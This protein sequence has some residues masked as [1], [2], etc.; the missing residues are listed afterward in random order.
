[1]SSINPNHFARRCS[2]FS[3]INRKWST[4]L[5]SF[6]AD[7]NE[8]LACWNDHASGYIH[9]RHLSVLLKEDVEIRSCLQRMIGLGKTIESEFFKADRLLDEGE[10]E[11]DET[12]E[13]ITRTREES[14]DAD[15]FLRSGTAQLERFTQFLSESRS[16]LERAG[17]RT[18]PR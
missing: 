7:L 16:L 4:E 14:R 5:E 9:Q 6:D 18:R 10:K 8:L 12:E 3:E 13:S 11:V 2:A 1:M 15:E 17:R